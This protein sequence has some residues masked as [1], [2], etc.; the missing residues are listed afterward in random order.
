MQS[1]KKKTTNQPHYYKQKR[2]TE[3]TKREYR[4][5]ATTHIWF[6]KEEARISFLGNELQNKRREK[7]KHVCGY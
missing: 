2:P 4:K 1:K 6:E 7:R 3:G 5:K